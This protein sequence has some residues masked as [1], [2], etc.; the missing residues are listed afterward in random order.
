MSEI[1][2][3][4]E[5]KHQERKKGGTCHSQRL[6]DMYHPQSNVIDK[7]KIRSNFSHK[8]EDSRVRL[9]QANTS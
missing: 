2:L 1:E 8:K 7:V 3:Q 5:K 6:S 9:P 4:W